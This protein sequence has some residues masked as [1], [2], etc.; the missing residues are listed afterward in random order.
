MGGLPRSRGAD[1]YFFF[2]LPPT[3]SP[4]DLVYLPDKSG[5]YIEKSPYSFFNLIML[6]YMYLILQ[7]GLTISPFPPALE[8]IVNPVF[9]PAQ[10]SVAG[11]NMQAD[12][13]NCTFTNTYPHS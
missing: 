4:V 1:A 2:L 7:E 13:I 5:T 9:L 11:F 10:Y 6:I 12:Y 8:C 3:P